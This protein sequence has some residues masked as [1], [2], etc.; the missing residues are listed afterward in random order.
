MNWIGIALASF[1]GAGLSALGM[2]GGGIL[3]I[4][5][6]A[7]VGM[8]QQAAQGINLVFF[9]PVA[10]V[11]ICIHAKNKLIRWKL[12]PPCVILGLLGVWAGS[13]IALSLEPRLLGKLF[14]GF[15]FLIGIRELAA[16]PVQEDSGNT[17]EK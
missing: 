10:L 16:R 6:T 14:G 13:R 2:G 12:V 5:L 15:L 11:A 7:V 1:F 9:V 4:Y 8:R 17:V 3:L